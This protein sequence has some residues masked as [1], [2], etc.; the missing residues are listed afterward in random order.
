MP[1]CNVGIDSNMDFYI[2]K[3]NQNIGPLSEI[4][5]AEGLRAGRLLPNDLGCRVGENR[6]VDLELLFPNVSSQAHSCI[7]PQF[8]AQPKAANQSIRSIHKNEPRPQWPAEG[9]VTNSQTPPAVYQQPPYGQNQ[10]QHRP[11]NLNLS[12]PYANRDYLLGARFVAYFVDVVCA[13]PLLVLAAIP[14]IGILGAP[15]FCLYLVSRDSIFGGQSIGKRVMGL[16]V[17]KTDGS[18]FTWA[19]SAKRNII[20]FVTLL[21]MVPWAGHVLH[22]AIGVPLAFVEL[23]LVLTGGLRIGDR[24]GNTYVVR[25]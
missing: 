20:Y 18:A 11:S 2:Y 19:D 1:L 9:E 10:I 25:A 6:W 16:R 8:T 7:E 15:L 14:F 12:S 4:Q 17:I 22:L 5:V 21:L 24:M 13:I 3:N 23:I